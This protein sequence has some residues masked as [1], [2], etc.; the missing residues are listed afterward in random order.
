MCRTNGSHIVDGREKGLFSIRKEYDSWGILKSHRVREIGA[1]KE[2]AT[3]CYDKGKFI[4]DFDETVRY[5]YNR[6]GQLHRIDHDNASVVRFAYDA[7]G[8]LGAKWTN[9][10][11][12]T[13]YVYDPLD[14][15]LSALATRLFDGSAIQNV[16][17]A[18][19][20]GRKHSSSCK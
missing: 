16:T 1:A 5:D 3:T 12:T 10:G 2:P 13:R 4:C 18:Y 19:E 7:F 6:A 9:E 17:Y 14:W 11:T 8:A 20:S 15:R